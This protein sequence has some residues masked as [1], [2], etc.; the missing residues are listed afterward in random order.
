MFEV[1]VIQPPLSTKIEEID[2]VLSLALASWLGKVADSGSS[3]HNL[4]GNIKCP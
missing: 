4:K 2:E 1:N 3:P